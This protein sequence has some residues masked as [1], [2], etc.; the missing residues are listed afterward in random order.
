[1]EEYQSVTSLMIVVLVSF[2]VPIAM[3][4][5]KLNWIP[6]VVAEIIVGVALGKSGFQLIHE[7]N[8]LQLLSM[9][10]IIY[11]MFLSGLE[12][13][14]DLIQKSR[15]HSGKNGNPLAI[16]TVSYIGIL[17][18]S[19]ALS[20]IIHGLGYTKDVFFM[21]L[22]ISTI[23]VS[24]T[25]PV[26]KDKGLLNDPVGQSVLLTAVIA[27]F[28]TMLMLAVHVSLH[29]S[30]EGAFNTL[31][32][33]LLFVAFFVVYRLVRLFR[34]SRITEKIR[35][36][37]ISI[38]TRGVFAL[39]L[40]FVAVSEG[41]GAE[42]IL[43]AFLAGVIVSLMSP[44][45]SFVQQLNAF[46]YGF[47]IPIF[48]VMVGADLD[49]IA[50]AQDAKALTVLP[51]LLLAFYVSRLLV[52]PIFR[53]WFSWKESIA[54]GVLLS[55]TLSL[56]IAAAKVG[57]EMGILDRTMNTALVL[58]AVIA[59]LVS[60]VLFQRLM[61]DHR[62]ERRTKV[63][64]VGINAVTLS[65]ARDL[66]RDQYDVTLYGSD[67]SNLEVMNDRPFAIVQLPGV[68]REHLESH[69][70]FD[71]DIVVLFTADDSKNFRL[72]LDAEQ[73]GVERIIA[74][75]ENQMEVSLPEDSRIRL[76]SS[77]FA[78]KTLLRSLIEFPSLVR[79]VSESEGYLQEVPLYNHHFNGRRI[80][81][82]P[83]IG[84]TLII[85]IYRDGEVIM[86]RGDT[87]LRVGDRLIISGTPAHVRKVERLLS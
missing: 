16:G 58:S 84:D 78:N 26:L 15:K 40:F 53:R 28:F 6:V 38:G 20:W 62:E 81:D 39:I 73:Q 50:L 67:K 25:L 8:L 48:F 7:D 18:L 68:E 3:H 61:P 85:R 27:D 71:S 14:F 54:S 82:L 57:E 24:I 44:S 59:T 46:G 19:L 4:R 64:L 76:I 72:A 32:L 2:F 43:G 36:E 37:T 30:E 66:V 22:I 69:R 23:S 42:N 87:E 34:A 55:S 9:L 70:V 49:L 21:T 11:L 17:L 77:F 56:V 47:L 29:R 51:L 74:R 5:L 35:R 75:V 31:W 79:F 80:R 13:D 86:P 45:K 65:L 41:V 52:V 83:F 10:G 60:P 63:A 12:I 33:L 1:M